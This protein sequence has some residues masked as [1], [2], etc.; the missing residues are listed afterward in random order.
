M[1]RIITRTSEVYA[2]DPVRVLR[3]NQVWEDRGGYY[4][5]L[6]PTRDRLRGQIVHKDSFGRRIVIEGVR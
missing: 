3:P 5:A 4:H 1:G 2:S 6:E